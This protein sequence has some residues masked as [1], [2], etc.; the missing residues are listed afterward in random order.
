MDNKLSEIDALENLRMSAAM[1]GEADDAARIAQDG[2]TAAMR[3]SGRNL[4]ACC[5]AE[6]KARAARVR[7]NDRLQ[8]AARAYAASIK[9]D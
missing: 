3:S 9:E 7:A 1:F 2:A 4:A 6:R 8:D 5:E